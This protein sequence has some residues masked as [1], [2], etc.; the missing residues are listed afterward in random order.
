MDEQIRIAGKV[1]GEPAD[2]GEWPGDEDEL[3]GRAR[4]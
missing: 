1:G 4:Q 3:R 2:L